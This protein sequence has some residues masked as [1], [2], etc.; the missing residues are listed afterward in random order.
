VNTWTPL[1]SGTVESSLWDE[2]DLVVKVFLT[3]I[4][5]KDSDQVYRGDA[6]K[7][8]RQ[9][10]KEEV[11]VLEALKVLASPDS[12]KLTPQPHGGRRIQ[13]VED[14]WLILNG[15]KYRDKVREEMKRARNRRAQAA[16]RERQKSAKRGTNLPGEREY[17][18]ALRRG[19]QAA[20]EAVVER[21]LPMRSQGLKTPEEVKAEIDAIK[22]EAGSR[23]GG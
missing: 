1:W 2:S 20:A 9:S 11:E 13:A 22:A 6:Y 21:H 17:Q 16:Y 3:M 12:K 10:R 19:D 14:G 4:A 23:N 8:A 5:L 7:L 18:E 15:E